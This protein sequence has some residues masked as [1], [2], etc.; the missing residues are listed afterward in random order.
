[1]AMRAADLMLSCVFD[2]CLSMRDMETERRPYHRNCNCALHK[3]KG[4]CSAGC[5]Q[6]KNVLFPMK[7]SWKDC[8]LSMAVPSDLSSSK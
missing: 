8:S 4:V 1:M 5:P 7:Q 6:Q 2:A 3:T